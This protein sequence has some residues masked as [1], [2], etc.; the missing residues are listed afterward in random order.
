MLKLADLPAFNNALLL[1]RALTHTSFANENAG[2]EDNERLEFLGDSVLNYIVADW[3]YRNF[4]GLG[5]GRLT[6]MRAALV[7]AERLAEFAGTIEL[8]GSLR[9]GKGESA[10]SGKRR[11]N[12]LADAFEALTAA[13]YLDHGLGTARALVEP[14]VEAVANS[15]LSSEQDRDPKTR[16]QEWSQAER[17]VTPRYALANTSGPAHARH[18]EVQ[19][20]LGDE[21]AASGDGLSKQHAELAAA[22]AALAKYSVP[23]SEPVQAE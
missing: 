17:N 8:E 14:L 13:V 18:F 19:V 2:I 10:T 22:R 16:L 1:E 20:W 11:I 6:T 5:E 12:I 7:R 15:L 9:F 21:M 3:L 4:S 23:M